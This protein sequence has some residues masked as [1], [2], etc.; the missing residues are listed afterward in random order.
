MGNQHN[1]QCLYRKVALPIQVGIGRKIVLVEVV[2]IV[3]HLRM[4]MKHMG[5]L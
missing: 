1:H 4:E 5:R 2:H 3:P